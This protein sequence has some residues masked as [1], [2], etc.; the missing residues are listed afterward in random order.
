MKKILI[1][2]V[3][4]FIGHHLS[5]RILATTDWEVYGMDMQSE[6]IGDLLPH[7][8]FHFFEGDITINKEWIAYH[9]KKCDTL[10]PL[11]AIATPATYVREPLRVFELDFEANLPI[12][13]AAV[14]YRKRV[15]FPSTSEVY[16][17]CRDEQFDAERSELVL[18]PINKP[19][20][21]YSCA[22]QLMDRVIHA[23]GMEHGLDYTLFRPFNWI[24]PGLD[25]IHT[26]KEGSSRV[27]TQFLGNI[28]RGEPIKLVDGGA[29]KRAFTY[30][31]D[32][33]AALMTLI[34]N[35]SGIAS[36]KI[37]NIG[38]PANNY[39]VRELAT[40]M[41][42]MA[43]QYPEYAGPA[44]AVRLV[45]T[46]SGEYYGEGYQDVQNRV[47]RID[48]TCADLGWA[49]TV[50]MP[51]ALRRIFDAYRDHVGEARK[52]VE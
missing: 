10:L 16:G 45:E 27:I 28:V 14:A 24:G 29:Q 30:V 49:P 26:P 13:R 5:Q 40:M 51:T 25:S 35:P 19:R 48:N 4:G 18:G 43:T 15:I 9:V 44:A 36:G 7:S 22:K 8:R 12:I 17:M 38:N 50:D 39:S 6:R 32:G 3:N 41:L 20:W 21:I 42:A 31:D 23:Y 1:L 11:V 46:T 37:Y 52:L 33:I 2:G 34:A 47:P